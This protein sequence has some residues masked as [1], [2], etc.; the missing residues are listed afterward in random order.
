MI[1][2]MSHK[3]TAGRRWKYQRWGEARGAARDEGEERWEVR[4][5]TNS[6]G[7]KR[8]RWANTVWEVHWASRTGEGERGSSCVWEGR[9]VRRSEYMKNGYG[10]RIVLGHDNGGARELTGVME[11]HL[12]GFVQGSPRMCGVQHRRK[13][14]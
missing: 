3:N 8:I 4:G 10:C 5:S 9:A 12:E 2:I 14:H 1:R 7:E 11:Q 6:P 13:H